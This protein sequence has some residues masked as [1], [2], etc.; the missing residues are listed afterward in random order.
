MENVVVWRMKCIF[1][2]TNK[3][4]LIKDI[5]KIEVVLGSQARIYLERI[6]GSD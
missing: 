1:Y 4:K 3:E 6:K 5:E 2:S